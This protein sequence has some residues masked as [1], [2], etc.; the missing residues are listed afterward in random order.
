MIVDEAFE[1]F[2]RIMATAQVLASRGET[3]EPLRVVLRAGRGLLA[4]IEEEMDAASK[5]PGNSE[6]RRDLELSRRFISGIESLVPS[7]PKSG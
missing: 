4:I 2:N 1:E 3:G 6:L 5:Q 7:T